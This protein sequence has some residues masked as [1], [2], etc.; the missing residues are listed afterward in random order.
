[1]LFQLIC[2]HMRH[3]L[4]SGYNYLLCESDDDGYP[5]LQPAIDQGNFPD[6]DQS[7]LA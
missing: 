7:V 4:F 5:D 1:M 2:I 6:P 3:N